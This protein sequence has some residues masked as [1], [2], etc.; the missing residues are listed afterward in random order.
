MAVILEAPDYLY[1]L[2]V[3]PE[4]ITKIP[5]KVHATLKKTGKVNPLY[6]DRSVKP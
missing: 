5:L 6:L 3:P 2:P 4:K 1:R